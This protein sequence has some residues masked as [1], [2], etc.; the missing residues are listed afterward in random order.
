MKVAYI[1]ESKEEKDV[2]TKE[3]YIFSKIIK[4]II[5][6]YKKVFNKLTVIK[7]ENI[8]II[9][10]P[11]SKKG[12][13]QN[14]LI[15]F[16][17]RCKIKHIVLENKLYNSNND[18][19]NIIYSSDIHIFDGRWIFK[20]MLED[21]VD[22]ILEKQ[23]TLLDKKQISILVNNNST[24]NISNVIKISKKAKNLNV[25]T[26]NISK[27]KKVEE[28]LYDNLGIIVTVTNNKRKCLKKSD[29]IINIDFPIELLQKYNINKNSII[30]NVDEKINDVNKSFKGIIINDFILSINHNINSIFKNLELGDN[31]N[32]NMIYESYL[33]K[34]DNLDNL[35]KQIKDCYIE[36]VK[37]IGINGI[38]QDDEF[39]K[40]SKYK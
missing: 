2:L 23:N 31:F 8:Y 34:K 26:N 40:I 27:F 25:V 15:N 37:L 20:I 10:I 39:E 5:F 22:F 6:I 12:R 11:N 17:K 9:N 3:Q 33:Y 28:Y 32:K 4:K 19:K 35:R 24:L 13:V 18:L 14:D 38:I 16:L 30:I 1:K 29:I 21:I 36:I 7:Q